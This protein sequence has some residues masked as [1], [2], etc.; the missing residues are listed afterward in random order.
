[1]PSF[2]FYVFIGFI[3][4]LLAEY[5]REEGVLVYGLLAVF[6]LVAIGMYFYARHL[7]EKARRGDE[8]GS[9]VSQFL[10]LAPFCYGLGMALGFG[11]RVY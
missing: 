2:C 10:L 6:N 1:M 5:R 4:A 7:R 9:L 3:T 11:I 8:I